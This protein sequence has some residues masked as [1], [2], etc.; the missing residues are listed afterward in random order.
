VG[1]DG[2]GAAEEVG[3]SGIAVEGG[4]GESAAFVG[5]IRGEGGE[6]ARGDTEL[7]RGESGGSAAV[8]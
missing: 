2:C 6:L 3:D 5:D 4:E 7:A 8:F 1:D